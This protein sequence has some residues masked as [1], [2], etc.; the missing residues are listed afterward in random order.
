M[1]RR[2]QLVL[3]RF[4]WVAFALTSA[5]FLS[6]LFGVV[7]VEPRVAADGSTASTGAFLA[8]GVGVS[9]LLLLRRWRHLRRPAPSPARRVWLVVGIGLS[10]ALCVGAFSYAPTGTRSGS[11]AAGQ[12]ALVII[13]VKSAAACGYHLYRGRRTPS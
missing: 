6:G 7:F 9:L 10:I 4:L 12:A 3:L 5:M 11:A 1:I 2:G 13:A 8:A